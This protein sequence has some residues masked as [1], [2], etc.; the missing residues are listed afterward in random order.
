MRKSLLVCLIPGLILFFQTGIKAQEYKN[1]IGGRFGIANG[2]TYKTF[3]NETNAL[4]LILNFRSTNSY[5]YF[6]LTGLYEVHAQSL[7]LPD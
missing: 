2:V 4:D 7:M 6:R 3:L 5:S 1:A